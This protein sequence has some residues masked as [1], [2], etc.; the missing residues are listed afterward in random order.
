M[1]WTWN[2]RGRT[3][4]HAH[5]PD[6]MQWSVQGEVPIMVDRPEIRNVWAPELAWDAARNSWMIFWSSSRTDSTDGNRIWSSFTKD[7]KSFSTPKLLFDPGYE[8]IDATMFHGHG[9]EYL[10]FKDQTR[11]PLR[12]QVRFATGPTVEG[13]WSNI[14]PPL[15]ESWSEGPSAIMVGDEH[16]I[17]YDHYRSPRARYEGVQS[18]DWVHWVSINN[19]IRF[20]EFCKH[21]SFLK[22]THAE[23]A[24]LQT[25]HDT[26]APTVMVPVP[27]P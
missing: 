11:D 8:V 23:A 17:Y 2:W 26:P 13:P 10:I 22:I 15:T 20:P 19:R 18:K 9:K 14:A 25:R 6:L 21:G 1:V 16:V 12:Y 27:Q 24:R 4:G 3:L 7:F 5:S